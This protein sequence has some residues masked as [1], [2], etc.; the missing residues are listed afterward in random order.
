MTLLEVF[1]AECKA[2]KNGRPLVTLSWAQSLDGS[3]S[4]R[5]GE[6]L[7]LSGPQ[8]MQLTHRLRAAHDAILVGIGTLLS[9]DPR[10]SVRLVEGR[11][12]QPVV[13]DS[14]LRFP[15]QA[16]LLEGARPPW[17]AHL[18][19]AD[20]E[21]QVELEGRGA[22]LLVLPPDEEGRVSL[23]A[24]LDC[25][26]ELGIRSLMVEGGASVIASFLAQG[27]ADRMLVTIAPIIVGG[28]HMDE[29]R[30]PNPAY[31]K[32]TG[33]ERLGEDLVVWGVVSGEK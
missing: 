16:A 20:P 4:A 17:I 25:L 29:G 11:D 30:L 22:R 7:R 1:L 19:G 15:S 14:R 2:G 27:L 10:L 12:P 21:K 31:V 24:L 23:P 28:L 26:S 33:F 9:D 13:L 6:P 5:R 32:N 8:S 3:L 18:P